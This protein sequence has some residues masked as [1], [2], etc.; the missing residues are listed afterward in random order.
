MSDILN[1]ML[2]PTVKVILAVI[3]IVIIMLYLLSIVWVNLDARK[4]N[5]STVL[6]SV[7]AVIPVAGL[8]AY[9]LLR[10]ALTQD[11]QDEQ[12]MSLDLLQRQLEEYGECPQCGASVKSDFVAC[13]YCAQQLRNVCT[14]CGK[15]LE[16]EWRVCPY[17]TTPVTVS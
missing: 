1:Q 14:R 17:C 4:R 11:D 15:V 2:T 9:C 5:T 16:A 10:P 3:A 7:V 13:P 6:W 12:D 8:V